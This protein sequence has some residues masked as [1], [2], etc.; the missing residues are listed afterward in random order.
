MRDSGGLTTTQTVDIAPN[1]AN[2]TVQ[3]TPGAWQVTVDGQPH[4]SGTVLASVVGFQRPIGVAATRNQAR[5]QSADEN[6]R[7]RLGLGTMRTHTNDSIRSTTDSQKSKPGRGRQKVSVPSLPAPQTE[8]LGQFRGR[9][10]TR[11]R[12]RL[13]TDGRADVPIV[14]GKPGHG[15]GLGWFW[16]GRI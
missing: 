16:A 7:G 2:I 14:P 15:T 4:N 10:S 9:H 8:R 5:A 12:C 1:V 13:Q 3:T 6:D 11:D